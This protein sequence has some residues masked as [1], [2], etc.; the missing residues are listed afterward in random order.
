MHILDIISS[1]YV[2]PQNALKSMADGASPP[3][4][5]AYSAPTDP[6]AGFTAPISKALLLR[7]R[8]GGEKK[9]IEER[10]R[11]NDLC[12]RALKTLAPSLSIG[13]FRRY[14]SLQS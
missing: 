10:G 12:P 8:M 13:Q 4:G 7:Q 9:G 11:Q 5:R 1:V 6:L 14:F 3:I 2:G